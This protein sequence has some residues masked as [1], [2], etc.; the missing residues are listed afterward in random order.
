MEVKF[1]ID[2]YLCDWNAR[3]C[4][5][6][7]AAIYLLARRSIRI[8]NSGDGIFR[9]RQ[10]DE[11]NGN[12]TSAPWLSRLEQSPGMRKDTG[13]K[14]AGVDFI[15]LEKSRLLVCLNINDTFHL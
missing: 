4:K 13:S 12:R 8:S 1:R 14:P 3:F 6:N 10:I 9:E 15:S 11:G 5:N 7:I 2:S